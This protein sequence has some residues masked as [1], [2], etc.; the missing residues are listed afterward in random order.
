LA[1]P[2]RG[3]LLGGFA[4]EILVSERLAQSV[5]IIVSHGQVVAIWILEPKL[6]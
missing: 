4:Q 1:L 5:L 6:L 3:L 2:R